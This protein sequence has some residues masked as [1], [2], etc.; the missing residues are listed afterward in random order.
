MAY[1]GIDLSTVHIAGQ[2]DEICRRALSSGDM[3]TEKEERT[4][5]CALRVAYRGRGA[6]TLVRVMYRT[7]SSPPTQAE[8]RADHGLESPT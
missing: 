6:I 7:N 4:A 8:Q 1:A 3:D 2:L 5:C